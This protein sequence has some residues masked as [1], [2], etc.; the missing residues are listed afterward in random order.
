MDIETIWERIKRHE[1]ET[2]STIRG[3]LFEYEIKGDNRI[4]PLPHNNSTIFP[5]LKKTIEECL[6]LIP[7]KNT[8]LVQGFRAP[9]YIFAILTDKRIV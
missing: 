1:G 4:Q 3:I 7:L 5:I 6:P 8:T 2:F 9:S